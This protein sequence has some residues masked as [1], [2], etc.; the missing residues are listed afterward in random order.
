MKHA[1]AAS[2]AVVALLVPHEDGA[3]AAD[4]TGLAVV[5]LRTSFNVLVPQF[6]AASGHKVKITYGGSSD[7]S[8]QLTAGEPFDVAFVWPAMVERLIKEGKMVPDSRTEIAR[9]GIGVAVRKGAPKPDISTTA[10]FKRTLLNA[11]SVSHSA[12]GASGTYF[13]ALLERL[14][15]AAEM[16]PKLRP[17]QG[18]PLVVGPVARG[19]AEMAVITIPFVALEPGADLVGPLPDELQDY[20]VYTAGIGAHTAQSDAARALLRHLTSPAAASVFRTN[21]LDPMAQGR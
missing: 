8:R 13:K 17:Q 20:V 15:I 3:R 4:I 7:L 5:P 2:M 21:G 11:A 18:G 12:E 19:E 9:V 6:E 16:Q 14:G 1:F 10:A